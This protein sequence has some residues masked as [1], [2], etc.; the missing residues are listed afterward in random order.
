MRS[1]IDTMDELG[2]AIS[3]AN[4]RYVGMIDAEPPINSGESYPVK[5][6]EAIRHL[7]TDEA[8][9]ACYAKAHEYALQENLV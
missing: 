3:P 7:W 2:L 4:R 1:I 5:Y 9:Q 6:L 8:V